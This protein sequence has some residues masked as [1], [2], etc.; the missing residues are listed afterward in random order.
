M[1]SRCWVEDVHNLVMYPF[2][3]MFNHDCT[4]DPESTVFKAKYN[5]SQVLALKE[6]NKGD[7]VCI[8]YGHLCNEKL[9][10]KFGFVP[11]YNPFDFV[12]MSLPLD[13]EGKK[14]Q[15]E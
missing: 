12:P 1:R 5:V 7:H 3:D 11:S 14:R 4:I 2:V 15:R 6:Y 8:T 13:E 9:L 10:S